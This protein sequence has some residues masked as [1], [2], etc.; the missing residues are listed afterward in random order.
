MDLHS[1]ASRLA[2]ASVACARAGRTCTV[3]VVVLTL[4]VAVASAVSRQEVAI[5]RF[6]AYGGFWLVPDLVALGLRQWH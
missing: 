2:V 6:A 3:V 5:V 1:R 4:A